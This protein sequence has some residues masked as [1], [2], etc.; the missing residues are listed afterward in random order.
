MNGAALLSVE[1]L[2]KHFPVQRSLFR[3]GRGTVVRA[4]NG[5]SFELRTGET[6]ALVGETGCGKT[7][8]ARAVA[9]LYRPTTGRVRFRGQ[10]MT[11]LRRRGLKAARRHIGL[12][13]QDPLSSLNPRL[14][15]ARLIAEPLAIHGI[16]SSRQRRERAFELAAAV[17]IAI[18]DLDRHPHAFSGGQCQRIAIA[19]AL[20][21][22]PALVIADEPVSSLDASIQSQVLNLLIDMKE[23]RGLSY[24]FI[25]HDIAVADAIADRVAVMYA[26]RIVEFGGRDE[27]FHHPVH[28]YTRALLDAVPQLGG[29]RGKARSEPTEPPSATSSPSGCPYHPRCPKAQ[30]LCKETMPD[31]TSPGG[32]GATLA[33]CHF[34]D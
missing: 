26:G 14:S 5:V 24:L 2:V 15:V 34:P 22:D 18:G 3:L 27:V 31:L 29:D 32:G 4:V 30:A 17:G 6:L 28:P 21:S 16:G 23:R 1:G 7:T 20:A 19:R 12:I 13:F 11:R 8:V 33:A 9:M 25:T 10:D